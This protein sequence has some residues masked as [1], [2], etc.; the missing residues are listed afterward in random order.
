[1]KQSL[2]HIQTEYM[3]LAHALEHGELTP[4]LEQ[5]LAITEAALEQ[6]AIGYAHII[7]DAESNVAQINAEI[8]RLQ[9]LKKSEQ[10]KANRLKETIANAMQM[11]G[12]GEVKTPTVRLSFRKSE[13]VIG[14]GELPDELVTI[15]PET[16]K[17]NLTAI[18]AA[19]KAG[20]QVEGYTIEQRQNLQIK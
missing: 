8:A 11:F 14:E 10:N 7:L 9:D 18:K 2:Y 5:Q 1:M 3:Q 19:I 13:A 6:K 20:E 12:V 16:R 4:E 17:P 15:V